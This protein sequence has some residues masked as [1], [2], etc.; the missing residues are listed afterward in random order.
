VP[1]S[2]E[3]N[4]GWL[5]QSSSNTETIGNLLTTERQVLNHGWARI[6]AAAARLFVSVTSVV[7]QEHLPGNCSPRV[8]YVLSNSMS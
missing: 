1:T 7:L 8:T 2:N 6:I 3:Q 5:T 4:H